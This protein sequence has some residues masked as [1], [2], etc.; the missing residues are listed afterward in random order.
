MD[1]LLQQLQLDLTEAEFAALLLACAHGSNQEAGER[2]L[3]RMGRELTTLSDTSLAVA[4]AFF[5]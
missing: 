3:Q 4:A 1:A 2:V 5:E